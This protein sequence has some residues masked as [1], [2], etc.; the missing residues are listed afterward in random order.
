MYQAYM[1][2]F[3]TRVMLLQGSI[4]SLIIRKCLHLHHRT[5]V[6]WQLRRVHTWRAPNMAAPREPLR[7]PVPMS[8]LYP[9]NAHHG[10]GSRDN[11]GSA[12]RGTGVIH[13]RIR[14]FG[15][16]L[17]CGDDDSMS[18][19]RWRR[20]PSNEFHVAGNLGDAV[21][22]VRRAEPPRLGGQDD[23]QFRRAAELPTAPCSGCSLR[24]SA[25][26][27]AAE[28]FSFPHI[29]LRD[30]AEPRHPLPIARITSLI[31]ST[32]RNPCGRPTSGRLRNTRAGE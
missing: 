13:S 12:G 4:E 5:F 10:R 21:D 6:T 18:R 19:G 17:Q 32:A 7:R 28:E 16:P 24:A 1:A 3:L 23:Q 31:H 15:Q 2:V 9:S 30:A 20:S 26:L 22:E 25:A 14:R 8:P 27:G 11:A 29:D